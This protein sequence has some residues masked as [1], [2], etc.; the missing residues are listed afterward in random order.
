MKIRAAHVADAPALAQVLIDTGR[1]AHQ[2]Q[3]PDEVLMQAPLAEAYAE[4]ERNWAR[5]LREMAE[6]VNP[7]EC[8][9]VAE[10]KTGAVV[11]L[12]MGGPLLHE[13][14]AQP[15]G[16]VY[17]LY[18]LPSHQ[19]RGLGRQLVQ[20]IAAH[21]AQLGM[22][23]LRIGCLAANAPARRFYEALGGSVVGERMF[24]EGGHMLPGVIYGWTDTRALLATD[25]A[26]PEEP[27]E[28]ERAS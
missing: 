1:I 14:G 5:T 2:G 17:A 11:G 13:P 28:G 26:G 9:Y 16:E 3:V 23:A 10:E 27:A 24:E 21:L 25:S 4:S 18:V 20:A 22:S 15:I 8:L 19:G 12:G 7:Q 6:E